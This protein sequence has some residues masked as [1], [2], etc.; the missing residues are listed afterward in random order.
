MHEKLVFCTKIWKGFLPRRC[1]LPRPPPWCQQKRSPPPP[2]TV[3]I[4]QSY[5]L[6]ARIDVNF[7][8]MHPMPV[9]KI[10]KSS[11]SWEGI[12]PPTPSPW[13][14]IHYLTTEKKTV[15]P[16]PLYWN[17]Y[18]FSA[19][20]DVN[21]NFMMHKNLNLVLTFPKSP[22]PPPWCPLS[23]TLL[24]NRNGSPSLYR[25]HKHWELVLML[26]KTLQAT[27]NLVLVPQNPKRPHTLPYVS[28]TLYLTYRTVPPPPLYCNHYILQ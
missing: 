15:S 24:N 22:H 4:L 5:I 2:P 26:I 20:I 7:N 21:L 18:T 3:C 23:N 1:S 6:G 9:P 12:P 17:F 10:Q 13:C 27:K 14:P 8:Y 11:L 16:N 25:N 19:I 28:N